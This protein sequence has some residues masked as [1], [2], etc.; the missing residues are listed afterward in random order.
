MFVDYID[1]NMQFQTTDLIKST[2][3]WNSIKVVAKNV[4]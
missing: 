2:A 3:E 4:L 1:Q